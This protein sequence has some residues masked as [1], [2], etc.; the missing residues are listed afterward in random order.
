MKVLVFTTLFFLSASPFLIGQTEKASYCHLNPSI[1]VATS[2]YLMENEMTTK[3][4]IEAI[5]MR[6]G[7]NSPSRNN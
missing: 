2:I 6:T 4:G 1:K 5:G 3:S 7:R